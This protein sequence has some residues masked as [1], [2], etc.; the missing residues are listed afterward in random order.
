MGR[1]FDVYVCIM[2]RQPGNAVWPKWARWLYI[3]I[4]NA[5]VFSR[6]SALEKCGAQK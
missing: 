3:D 4:I 5:I 2:K 6:F 1:V